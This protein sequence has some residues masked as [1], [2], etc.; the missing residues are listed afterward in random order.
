MKSPVIKWIG[1]YTLSIFV[2]ITDLII[3]IISYRTLPQDIPSHLDFNNTPTEFSQKN[4]IFLIWMFHC[5]ILFVLNVVWSYYG[6]KKEILN[7]LFPPIIYAQS[8][9]AILDTL[10][11][12]VVSKDRS[13]NYKIFSYS[14]NFILFITA[15]YI[16]YSII[17]INNTEYRSGSIK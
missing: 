17:K 3:I 5:F 13:A 8:L 15:I 9:L 7:V 14:E 6:R 10:R 16:V 2:C 4:F 1:I 11:T 12:I